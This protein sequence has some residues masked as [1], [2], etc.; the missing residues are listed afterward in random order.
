[1]L[2]KMEFIF[3]FKTHGLDFFFFSEIEQMPEINQKLQS[4][5]EL[6]G[7]APRAGRRRKVENYQNVNTMDLRE[8]GRV[9]S[10]WIPGEQRGEENKSW[11]E[12]I[13]STVSQELR[14]LSELNPE[15]S[16]KITAISYQHH[17][18][19]CSW[20]IFFKQHTEQTWVSLVWS[21]IFI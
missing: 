21:L 18:S 16:I 19:K 13:I 10:L 8:K 12:I 9:A 1:M 15:F 2:I 7:S 3:P 14:A 4:G 11:P 20:W 17:I 6:W 5:R